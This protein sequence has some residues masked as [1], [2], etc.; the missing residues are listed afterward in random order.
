MYVVSLSEINRLNDSLI[1]GISKKKKKIVKTISINII[2]KRPMFVDRRFVH[3][4]GETVQHTA[5]IQHKNCRKL[6]E[7][8]Y[9]FFNV[10]IL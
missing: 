3:G 4:D 6:A 9:N 8:Y 7:K 2:I 10:I 5:N 1:F